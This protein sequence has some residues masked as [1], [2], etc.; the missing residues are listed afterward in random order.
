MQ[1]N[2]VHA[3]EAKYAK[4]ENYLFA[5]RRA[6]LPDLPYISIEYDRQGRLV[7][8]GKEC[9]HPVTEPKV[10]DFAEKFRQE[11]LIPFIQNKG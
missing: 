9:C 2:I 10:K 11:V 8:Y 5:L 3:A 7:A 1:H 4:G 6:N